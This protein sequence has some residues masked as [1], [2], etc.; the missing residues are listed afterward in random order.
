MSYYEN[1]IK[2]LEH[3]IEQMARA[4]RLKAIPVEAQLIDRIA[5]LNKENARLKALTA[6]MDKT[7]NIS[8]AGCRLLKAEVERLTCG[9]D[10]LLN[11][12]LWTDEYSNDRYNDAKEK[13]LTAKTGKQPWQ[14]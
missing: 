8:Q 6:E 5:E 11:T 10:F 12:F 4:N 1:R 14:R 13:W 2:E 9:G 7:I 3:R